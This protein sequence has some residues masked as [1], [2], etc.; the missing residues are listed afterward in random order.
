MEQNFYVDDCLRSVA[1]ENKAIRLV[2]ELTDL[3]KRGG[4]RLTKWISNSK[5]VLNAIPE[6]ERAAY[7]KN[8]DFDN[9]TLAERALEVCWNVQDDT[10][11]FK[12]T[13]KEKLATRRGI[14]AAICSVYDPLGFIS[15]CILPAKIILQELCAKGQLQM[16]DMVKEPTKA[17]TNIYT[18]MF[19]ATRPC[20]YKSQELNHFADASTQGYGEVSYL[21]KN[22]RAWQHKLHTS[23]S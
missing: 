5:S 22:R 19:K 18:T 12:I 7:V 6:S 21:R 16:D 13:D 23:N 2:H 8:L 15:P 20:R 4:F 1:T 17:R 10:F 9:E 3:L 14:L 11:S